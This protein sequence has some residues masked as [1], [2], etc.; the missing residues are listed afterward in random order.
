MWWEPCYISGQGNNKSSC[1]D[2]RRDFRNTPRRKTLLPAWRQRHTRHLWLLPNRWDH[3]IGKGNTG[4]AAGT[5]PCE[6]YK[7]W[8]GLGKETK[9]HLPSLPATLHQPWMARSRHLQIWQEEGIDERGMQQEQMDFSESHVGHSH[10]PLHQRMEGR[11]FPVCH[12]RPG[13]RRGI[14]FAWTTRRTEKC[15]QQRHCC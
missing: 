13:I 11:L 14:Q 8:K 7:I 15:L 3:K 5:S 1:Q 2:E 9:R 6:P 4:M 12:H 10:Q